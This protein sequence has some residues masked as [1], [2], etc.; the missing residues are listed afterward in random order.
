MR[1]VASGVAVDM[2]MDSLTDKIFGVLTIIDVEV[3]V[4]V[5][6]NVFAGVMTA[7]EFA[8]PYAI[9]GFRCGAACDRRPMADLDCGS[10]LHDR[11]P[12]YHV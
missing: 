1:I 9:A 12:S 2:L 11:M 4:D 5:N 7:F 6:A 10:V 8:M 3:L